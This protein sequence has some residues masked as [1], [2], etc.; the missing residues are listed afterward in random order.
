[1]FANQNRSLVAEMELVK[2]FMKLSPE[3]RKREIRRRLYEELRAVEKERRERAKEKLR[4]ERVEREQLEERVRIQREMYLEVKR[5]HEAKQ[6]A[7]ERKANEPKALQKNE[8][9]ELKKE[10]LHWKK[11]VQV[12]EEPRERPRYVHHHCSGGTVAEEAGEGRVLPPA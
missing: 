5:M 1:M 9:E 12:E 3:E 8:D 4:M 6:R 7:E 10:R 11:V 2:S